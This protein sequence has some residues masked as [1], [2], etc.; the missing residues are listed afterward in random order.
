[1]LITVDPGSSIGLA[2]QIAAQIRAR[3]ASGSVGAGE[4][5]PPARELA[6][7]LQ[8]NMH[9]VL[10]AFASLQAE[11]LIEVRRGRGAQVTE[12]AAGL[13]VS[14]WAELSDLIEQV[15]SCAER[16]GLS[17]KQLV[18]HIRRAKP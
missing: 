16:L 10:R 4:R 2:D 12:H 7:G 11:G 1:M 14:Q 13:Q 17:E 6:K 9:T 3:I 18:E 5:L 15:R 8:V